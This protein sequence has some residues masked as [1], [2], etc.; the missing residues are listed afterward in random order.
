M[1]TSRYLAILILISLFINIGLG[2]YV[3]DLSNRVNQLTTDY[4]VL[5]TNNQVLKHYIFL[6]LKE[7]ILRTSS[8]LLNQSVIY[9]G[10]GERNSVIYNIDQVLVSFR[11][12]SWSAQN[13]GS[14]Y[15]NM[16]NDVS[17]PKNSMLSA[18][19][20]IRNSVFYNNYTQTDIDYLQLVSNNL[21]SVANNLIETEVGQFTIL[22]ID[23]IIVKFYEIETN[24]PTSG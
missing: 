23:N 16:S 20:E 19:I 15:I 4:D 12:F 14:A 6:L 1:K 3:L 9:L 11:Y 7:D 24:V 10:E 13:L 17:A 22:D 21:N 18:L 8:N 5:N 2:W